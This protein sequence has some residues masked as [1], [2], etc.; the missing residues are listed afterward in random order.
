MTVGA[1]RMRAMLDAE[2]GR[3]AP[4]A[5]AAPDAP[6]VAPPTPAPDIGSDTPPPPP[7]VATP[8]FVAAAVV[9]QAAGG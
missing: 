3:V 5:A 2:Q 1:S 6:A 7:D 8:T 9:E 4:S